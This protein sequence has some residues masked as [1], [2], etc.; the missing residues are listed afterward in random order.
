MM[1]SGYV[2]IMASGRNG[3]IYLGVTSNLAKRVWEHR[4]GVVG[5]F[6]K[7]YG[8]KSLVWYEAHGSIKSARQRELQMKEW[9]RA[10]KLREIEGLNP[11]WEDLYDR[12]ALP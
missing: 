2:Y 4:N 9:K 12:I 11:D 10:W 5:G 3:T 1:T 8:C 6:T 7:K